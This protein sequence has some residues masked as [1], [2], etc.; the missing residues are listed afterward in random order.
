MNRS[1]INCSPTR[2]TSQHLSRNIA[3]NTLPEFQIRDVREM[4]SVTIAPNV[5]FKNTTAFGDL[6]AAVKGTVHNSRCR[7]DVRRASKLRHGCRANRRFATVSCRFAARL[8]P[9][10]AVLARNP[11][12][13]GFGEVFL[14]SHSFLCA[15][16]TSLPRVLHYRSG[17][18]GAGSG[19][20]AIVLWTCFDGMN[21]A[22]FLCFSKVVYCKIPIQILLISRMDIN[23]PSTFLA[24]RRVKNHSSELDRQWH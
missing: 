17:P 12:E 15:A 20:R 7:V 3:D 9:M 1:S 21:R 24:R 5:A 16:K 18:S 23:F 8:H 14:C 13:P 6:R 2:T 22:S 19:R 4:G 10:P 11:R